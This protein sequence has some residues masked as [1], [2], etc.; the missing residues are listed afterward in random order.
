MEA[1]VP[2]QTPSFIDFLGK[3]PKKFVSSET[4]GLLAGQAFRRAIYLG[5]KMPEGDQRPVIGLVCTATIATDRLK[6]G[7]H[8]AHIASWHHGRIARHSIYLEKGARGRQAEERVVSRL[9]LNALSQAYGLKGELSIHLKGKDRV[10]HCETDVA[11]L[12]RRVLVKEL[13]FF[14][15]EP[16]GDVL[17]RPPKLILSGSFNPLHSGHQGL[18]K[19]AEKLLTK[20]ASFELAAIN[21]DKPSLPQAE[22]LD[23]LS[24]FA[25]QHT[26]LVSGA[27]TFVEKAH[28]YPGATF[29]VGFDTAERI[30]Q[31]RFYNNSKEERDAAL[32]TIRDK[33]CSFLVAGRINDKGVFR[34][35]KSLPAP[36]DF[37]D[38]FRPL[39]AEKFRKDI[40]S[41]ELRTAEKENTL[42]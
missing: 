9:I 33:G 34:D 10:E 35:A 26:V 30:L 37:T 32:A 24:Q 23:R 40:S 19:T 22:I 2:Y 25:G 16:G 7:D 6:R 18:A 11:A 27:P 15:L 36:L 8:R 39:P 5:D 41:T 4:A 21:A 20:P 3:R 38:L 29:V 12:T 31:T 1:L 28:I 17:D 13:P 14:G 42:E